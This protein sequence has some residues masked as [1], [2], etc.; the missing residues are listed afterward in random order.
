MIAASRR[1]CCAALA[2]AEDADFTARSSSSP[3][4]NS[5][6]TAPDA[7]RPSVRSRVRR[8]PL[9]VISPASN[10]IVVSVVSLVS[11]FG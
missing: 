11:F 4:A 7:P 9:I 10:P 6:T 8:R 1:S 5:D 2:A 3:A